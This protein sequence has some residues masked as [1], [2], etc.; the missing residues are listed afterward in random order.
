MATGTV[1]TNLAQ[2][3]SLPAEA[4]SLPHPARLELLIYYCDTNWNV[5]WGRSDKLNTF[6]PFQRL[7]VP[8]KGGDKVLR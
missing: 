8:L 4:K 6:L 1:I 7:P 3:W 5:F 2:M